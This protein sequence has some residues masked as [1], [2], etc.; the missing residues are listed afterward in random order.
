[1]KV[2]EVVVVV[3]VVE[4]EVVRGDSSRLQVGRSGPSCLQSGMPDLKAPQ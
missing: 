2:V 4:E 1:M 3:K